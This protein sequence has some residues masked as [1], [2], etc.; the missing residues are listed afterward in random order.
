MTN[1]Q[2]VQK[3]KEEI[4]LRGLSSDTEKEY[5][6]SLRPFGILLRSIL[7]PLT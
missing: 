6:K 1:E 7:S 4:T 5:L 3:A 2:V